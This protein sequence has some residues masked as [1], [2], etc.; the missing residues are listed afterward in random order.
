MSSRSTQTLVGSASGQYAIWLRPPSANPRL[1]TWRPAHLWLNHTKRLQAKKIRLFDLRGESCHRTRK[2]V[3]AGKRCFVTSNSK[4]MIEDIE[5]G[6]EQEFGSRVKRI[7]VTSDTVGSAA[8]ERFLCNI[9]NESQNYDVILCS[10][11]VGTGVDIT[12]PKRAKIIDA[13]FGFFEPLIT[14]H[15]ECDQ[16]LARVRDPGEVNV[17]V[18]SRRFQFDTH[19]EAI[20]HELLQESMYENLLEGYDEQGAP[21]YRESAFIDMAALIWAQRRASFNNL[22]RHFVEYKKSQ[23]YGVEFIE[24]EEDTRLQG[25]ALLRAGHRLSE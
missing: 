12:F 19:A 8:V 15:F 23:G 2:T 13:V 16:Q 10:P 21:I 7:K 9:V 18:S 25:N 4:S 24:R 3:E 11:S 1:P 14:S 6:L 17:W 5:G 20:K 22:R